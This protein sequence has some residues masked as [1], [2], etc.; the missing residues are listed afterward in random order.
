MSVSLDQCPLIDKQLVDGHYLKV[1][2]SKVRGFRKG[3]EDAKN[4]IDW[5][6]SGNL[7]DLKLR[8]YFGK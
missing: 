7:D 6:S 8:G 3:E 2:V 4:D 1:Q 5:F